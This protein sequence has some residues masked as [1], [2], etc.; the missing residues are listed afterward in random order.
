[1]FVHG[2]RVY[3]QC[4]LRG[5]STATVAPPAPAKMHASTHAVAAACG[6]KPQI[7]HAVSCTTATVAEEPLTWFYSAL[8]ADTNPTGPGALIGG[9][10][11]RRDS[12]NV[13][14]H[15][16]GHYHIRG[17]DALAKHPMPSES[18]ALPPSSYDSWR[19]PPGRRLQLF[20][21]SWQSGR[22]RAP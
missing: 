13:L 12:H 1:M 20:S 7:S 16:F 18:A 14:W 15:V 17:R 3:V 21:S 22:P 19:Q 10:L 11:G 5:R 4:E 2:T 8:Q 6:T 9:C